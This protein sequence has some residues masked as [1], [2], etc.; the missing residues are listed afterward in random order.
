VKSLHFSG[1]GFSVFQKLFLIG[2]SIFPGLYPILPD[3]QE[4]RLGLELK[5]Q[6]A[7]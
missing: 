7:T 3:Y 1:A 5:T 2:N 4:D 6:S